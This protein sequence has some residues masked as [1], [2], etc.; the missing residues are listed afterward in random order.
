MIYE[1]AEDS[2]LIE[3]SVKQFAEGKSALDMGTGSGILAEVA[4]ATGAKSVLAVDVNQEAVNNVKQKGINTR[5]SDLFSNISEKFDLIIFNPP[6]LPKT[7]DEDAESE[8]ITTGGTHGYEIIKKFL[9]QARAH[10]N[11]NGKI[12]ILFSS[13]TGR[14]R[15]DKILQ[16]NNYKFKCLETNKLFFEELYVYETSID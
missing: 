7:K 14:E 3:K 9:I 2:F 5:H 1:P 11:P 12:L 6:Y 15:V 4:L 8:K 13:L 16:E 10:L